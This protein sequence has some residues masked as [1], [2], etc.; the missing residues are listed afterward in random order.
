MMNPN[1]GLLIVGLIALLAWFL[2]LAWE[3]YK[4]RQ[5]IELRKLIAFHMA[6]VDQAGKELG[7]LMWVR[8]VPDWIQELV[9]SKYGQLAAAMIIK[10]RPD[11]WSERRRQVRE[12]LEAGKP[13]AWQALDAF[14]QDVQMLQTA[15]EQ[16]LLCALGLKSPKLIQARELLL[17]KMQELT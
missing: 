5:Q 2:T 11:L 12:D 6:M 17:E 3:E 7:D 10:E 16:H 13:G 1:L 15:E 8:P 9:D 4:R 14:N